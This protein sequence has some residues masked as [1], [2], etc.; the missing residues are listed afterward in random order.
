MTNGRPTD[1][2]GGRRSGRASL[3]ARRT[4]R[5]FSA[6]QCIDSAA[7]LT[8]FG[9][10]SLFPALLAVFSLLGVAGEGS[11]AAQA[12]L[13][14]IQNIAPGSTADLVRGPILQFASSRAAGLGL[15]AGI[16]LAI[17]TASGYLGAF[18]RAMNRIDEVDEGR[19][20]WVRKPVQL[21]LTLA[22]VV[23]AALMAVLLIVSGPIADAIDSQLALGSVAEAVWAVGK[24]PVMAAALIV[25]I[26]ML[27]WA[28]P[29]ARA[30]RFRW[31]SPGSILALVALAVAT[32][33]FGVYVAN[34]SH[35]NTSYGTLGG[36]IVFLVWFWIANLVLLF[37]AEFDAVLV[38]EAGAV[39][40]DAGGTS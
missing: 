10:L 1:D 14:I 4:I 5:E 31:V 15:V 24:W 11:R 23:L 35:Y 22:L 33:G 26:A 12:I 30:S 29:N 32:L 8:Y 21:L 36:V 39:P 20:F 17:W 6:H 28:S 18:S 27:Y 13:G 38:D 34:F 9:V 19:P 37:G 3:V 25:T 40:T 16:V 2:P 7:A